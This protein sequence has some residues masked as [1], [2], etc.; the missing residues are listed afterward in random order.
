MDNKNHRCAYCGKERPESEMHQFEITFLN[1]RYEYGRYRKFVD[2]ATN[3]Y[4]K[5]TGCGGKDQM[6]HEG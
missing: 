3:W 6:A 2:K 5:D 4:C 1:G